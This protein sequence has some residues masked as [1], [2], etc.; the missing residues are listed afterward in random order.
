MYRNH[1]M[2]G[3]SPRWSSKLKVFLLTNLVV[4]S[5]MV[6]VGIGANKM[7]QPYTHANGEYVTYSIV[8]DS[9]NAPLGLNESFS[10]F[11]ETISK[12]V[13]F[14]YQSAKSAPGNHASLASGGFI[15]NHDNTQITSLVS[16]EATF[17]GQASLS[18]G[19]TAASISPNGAMTSA[20]ATTLSN[21]PYFFKITNTD[22]ENVLTIHEVILTYSCLK[23]NTT[24]YFFSNGGSAV[25]PITQAIGSPVTAPP[26]PTRADYYFDGWYSNYSLTNRYS[27]NVMDENN[28]Y[29]YASWITDPYEGTITIADFKALEP[30]DSNFYDLIGVALINSEDFQI[31]IFADETG[32]I[33]AESEEVVRVGDL[34]KVHGQRMTMYDFTVIGT[35]NKNDM[36]VITYDHDQS[37]PLTPTLHSVSDFNDFDPMDVSNW[38]TY[39]EISGEVVVESSSGPNPPAMPRLVDNEEMSVFPPSQAAYEYLSDYNGFVVSIRGVILPNMDDEE[40]P[41]LM[42][43]FNGNPDYININLS[44][45]ALLDTLEGMFRAYFEAPAYF[46]GQF[47]DL[48]STHPILN[49]LIEYAT[50]GDNA[51]LLD[52]ET[53]LISA[54]ISE[55]TDI[56]LHVTVTLES[57]AYR[58]F[59]VKLHVDP[60]LIISIAEF[61]TKP[62]ANAPL[63]VIS[64]TII[65]IQAIEDGELLLWVADA[66]GI[67]YVYSNNSS[68]LVGDLI[69]ASGVRMAMGSSPIMFNDP[70]LTVAQAI[71]HNNVMPLSATPISLSAYNALDPLETSSVFHYYELT[72]TLA[73]LNPQH[74]EDSPTFSLSVGTDPVISVTIFA[75][76]AAAR[77][78]L[79]SFDGEL[80]TLKGISFVGGDQGNEAVFLAFVDFPDSIFLA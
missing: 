9:S 60:A 17:T 79:N 54:D 53:K 42:F 3:T 65:A 27:F 16:V 20:L 36:F 29:L 41:S 14:D 51:S 61:N 64:G 57:E 13:A 73:N 69:I 71:S 31:I 78:T 77:D 66:T 59:D 68:L 63:Y 4:I 22:P 28:T 38:L 44:D 67:T 25:Y 47:A 23:T 2:P 26:A 74:P 34:V 75:V 7:R 12:D 21:N 39:I 30:E 5:A 56:D 43:I 32:T 46:P 72:G 76:N 48:P 6:M 8:L 10:T 49:I 24:M 70:S 35:E 55:V 18:T 15:A 11:T 1:G 45:E 58:T 62:I 50:F 52:L 80:V 37:V 33:L 19:L 40:H